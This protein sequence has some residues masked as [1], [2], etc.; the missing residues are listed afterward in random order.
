MVSKVDNYI[1]GLTHSEIHSQKVVLSRIVAV[2]STALLALEAVFRVVDVASN[3]IIFVIS[4]PVRQGIG[5]HKVL[6]NKQFTYKQFQEERLQSLMQKVVE[7]AKLALFSLVSTPVS[8]LVAPFSPSAMIKLHVELGLTKLTQKLPKKQQPQQ[9]PKGIYIPSDIKKEINEKFIHPHINP[10]ERKRLESYNLPLPQSILFHG[11][12]KSSCRDT[13]LYVATG[14][15]KTLKTVFSSDLKQPETFLKNLDPA[16]EIYLIDL[17]NK[18]FDLE[19]VKVLL[20]LFKKRQATY[21]LISKN[22]SSQGELQIHLPPP[23]DEIR[24]DLIKTRLADVPLEAGFDFNALVAATKDASIKKIEK[25]VKSIKVHAFNTKTTVTTASALEIAKL[26]HTGKNSQTTED[27]KDFVGMDDLHKI[28]DDYLAVLEDPENSKE[29]GISMPA[30]MILHGPPGCGK[31]YTAKHLCHYAKSKGVE[32]NFQQIKA[33]DLLSTWKG[34]TV[35]NM[36][37]AFEAAKKMAP[38]VLFVDECEGLL[39]SRDNFRDT[40]APE[41]TQELDEML[42]IIEECKHYGVI[43]VGATNYLK[44]IDAAILRTGRI[45]HTFEVKPPNEETRKKMLEAK[46]KSK[47]CEPNL[48]L[49]QIV[50]ETEGFTASDIETLV[51]SAAI[52]SWRRKTAIT[53][54][55]LMTA[56]QAVKAK[57]ASV[58]KKPGKG[59]SQIPVYNDLK[60]GWEAIQE[61]IANIKSMDPETS[62]HNR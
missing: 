52:E 41:R 37:K 51:N 61:I 7:P 49:T 43:F 40:L 6:T 55:I 4:E 42:Q 38:V 45:D 46:L 50:K 32:M 35:L 3:I 34:G 11:P 19:T 16:G 24:T 60:R 1:Y 54:D 53:I 62:T 58:D 31:T 23:N 2:A 30:G 29:Y 20:T 14:L 27:Q 17:D 57:K 25:L 13:A 39:P 12:S 10:E 56:L 47:K 59:S 26:M 15:N 28:F 9:E 5:L 48:D 33:S 18:A 36:R 22:V 8:L 44:S 21:I